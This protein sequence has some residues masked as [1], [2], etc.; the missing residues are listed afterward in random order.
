MSKVT[1]QE[2]DEAGIK[3]EI[4]QDWADL[5]QALWTSVIV[6]F[7]ATNEDKRYFPKQEDNEIFIGSTHTID[8]IFCNNSYVEAR[9]WRGET[10]LAEIR[11]EGDVNIICQCF[12]KIVKNN[13]Q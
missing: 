8:A 12:G 1:Q 11:Y 6:L 5:M 2:A 3:L 9:L 7:G 10:P 4:Y 13:L